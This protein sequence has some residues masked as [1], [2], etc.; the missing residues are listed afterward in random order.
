MDIYEEMLEDGEGNERLVNSILE[1]NQE[2]QFFGETKHF[3]STS[4]YESGFQVNKYMDA[5]KYKDATK[6]GY[7]NTNGDNPTTRINFPLIRFAEMLLFR[8]EAY[9]MTEKASLAKEDIN[10]IRRRSNLLEISHDPTMADLYHERRCELA[11]EFTDH[12]FD[13][14]RWNR[15]SNPEIKELATKELN[16]RPRVRIYEDRANPESTFEVGYY[17]DYVNKSPYE[18]YMMVFPY[19]PKQITKSNGMLKQNKGY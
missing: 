6:A 5:F 17:E 12:L 16:S 15:S 3:S 18:D 1:Y 7:V 10:R 9:I 11:F 8:A 14:K 2:F 4:D 19:S 13:L